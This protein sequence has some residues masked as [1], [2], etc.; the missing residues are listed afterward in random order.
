MSTTE[1][2]NYVKQKQTNTNLRH[3]NTGMWVDCD[4]FYE[5]SNGK[6]TIS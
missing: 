2:A 6:S 1:D 5:T 3:R 4:F